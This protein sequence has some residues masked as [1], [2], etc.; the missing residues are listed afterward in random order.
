MSTREL[1]CF[2]FV[3]VKPHA[4]WTFS[5]NPAEHYRDQDDTITILRLEIHGFEA[6]MIV[7]LCPPMRFPLLVPSCCLQRTLT[8]E[9]DWKR[10]TLI[11]TWFP[12]L[13]CFR[14]TLGSSLRFD[15]N[16]VATPQ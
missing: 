7:T 4:T 10:F 1:F 11:V 12:H 13:L 3:C 9:A 5:L 15:A 6:A 16:S 2:L 8:T 14:A